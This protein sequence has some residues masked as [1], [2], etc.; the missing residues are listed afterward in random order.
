MNVLII[1]ELLDASTGNVVDWL[2]KLGHTVFRINTEDIINNLGVNISNQTIIISIEIRGNKINLN[3]IDSVWYR[4]GNLVLDPKINFP[5]RINK[6]IKKGVLYNLFD[7][8][9][10]TLIKFIEYYL[11]RTTCIRVYF[12]NFCRVQT[13]IS[14]FNF[15]SYFFC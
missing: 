14:F 11:C 12:N 6:E 15:F 4:R 3:E 2:S 10:T 1:S 13:C 8:E 9:L 7:E 5:R